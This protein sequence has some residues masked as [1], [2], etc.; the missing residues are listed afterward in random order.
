MNR[1][2]AALAL[3]LAAVALPAHAQLAWLDRYD[4]RED[5]GIFSRANQKRIDNVAIA[6]VVG[7]ALVEGTDT[8][9]GRTAWQ[10]LDAALVTAAATES[11]KR[12]FTRPRP[13][14]EPDAGVWF[15]GGR[16][17]SFP[18]GEVAMMAAFTTP[19]IIAYKDEKPAVW[20]LAALPVYMAKARMAS[21][22][23]WL[24]DVLAGGAIGAGVGYLAARR[25]VPLVLAVTGRTAFVGLRYRF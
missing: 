15:A 16:H 14:E 12:A 13:A 19:F 10:A 22:G 21:Q 20:A 1:T 5:S 11:M 4:E 7:L 17:R 24:S 9:L 3:A 2:I 8:R 25:D 18:S 6:G 23:H